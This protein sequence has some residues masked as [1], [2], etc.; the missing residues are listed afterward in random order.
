MEYIIDLHTHTISSGHAYSTLEENVRGALRNKVKVLG[1]SDHAPNMPGTCH[2]F[3]FH[4]LKVIP[5]M[6]ENVRVLKGIE[7]NILDFNGNLDMTD[8]DLSKMDY[9]IASLHPPCIS[10]SDIET[11]TMGLIKII[12][13]PYVNIIGHPDDSRFPL[14]YEQIVL[15][16]KK[17]NV[18]L[19]INN[20]SLNP[21]GFRQNTEQNCETIMKLCI[22]H[23]TSIIFGSDAHISY[24]VGNFSFCKALAKKINFPEE[25]IVNTSVEKLSKFLNNNI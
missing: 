24:D 15:A 3:H 4:N 16:A 10:P 14:D 2:L 25:L 5:D 17:N 23:D 7:V 22:K 18:L 8:H 13:N 20:A 12:E 11:N 1:M 9:T 21:N 19:E 6:I